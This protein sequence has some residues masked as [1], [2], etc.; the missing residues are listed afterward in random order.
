MSDKLP[1]SSWNV[2]S[3]PFFVPLPWGKITHYC[4]DQKL[5]LTSTTSPT[6]LKTKAYEFV[7]NEH[8]F[9]ET[10][11]LE[12]PSIP[13]YIC[14]TKQTKFLPNF[15]HWWNRTVGETKNQCLHVFVDSGHYNHVLLS[16]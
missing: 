9:T 13:V 7:L 12:V 10:K 3:S 4:F 16:I 15:K 8:S 5:T 14:Q 2:L 6:T 11:E 1:S